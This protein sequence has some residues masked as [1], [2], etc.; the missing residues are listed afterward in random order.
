MN[1]EQ[2]FSA[3]YN[4]IAYNTEEI[5]RELGGAGIYACVNGFDKT[6]ALAAE[7]KDRMFLLSPIHLSSERSR[8]VCR[9]R[10]RRIYAFWPRLL[11]LSLNQGL[12]A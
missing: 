3:G 11:H 10:S 9:G 2:P 8:S 12:F 4:R 1:V 7:V 6:S 5:S